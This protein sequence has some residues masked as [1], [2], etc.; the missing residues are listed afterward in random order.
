MRL[1][2]LPGCEVKF[3]GGGA[4]NSNG[5]SQKQFMVFIHITLNSK[6]K[7]ITPFTN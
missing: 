1:F 7:V 4:N 5:E 3:E 2:S 6:P